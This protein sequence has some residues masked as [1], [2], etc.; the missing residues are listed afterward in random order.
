MENKTR[1]GRSRLADLVVHIATIAVAAAALAYLGYHFF[2]GF[3][4]DIETEYATLVTDSDVVPLDAYIMR[5]ESVIFAASPTSGHSVGYVF[6]DG[7]KVHGGQVVA[8]IYTGDGSSDEAIVDLDRRIDLLESSNLTDGMTS[9]DTYVIDSK[10]QNYYYL[11][12]QSTLLG[13]Y[14][15]LTKRR[16]ELLTLIN[17]RRILTGV[18]TGYSD[19]IE[20]LT[21]ERA[22][23]SAGQDTIA[24]S[25]EAPYVGYF[26]ST[27]DGY[28]ST[29]SASKVESLT[30]AEFD[31]MLSS[32]PTRYSDRAVGKMVSDFDWYIVCETTRDSLRY[33]TKGY[34]YYVNFPY[35]DDISIKMTLSN[36]VS[37]VGSDR[38]LLVLEAERIPEDFSFRRMQPVE[39]V[40]SSY[41]GY[42]VPISAARLVDGKQGVYIMIGN[43]IEFRE[44]DILL[45]MD[46]YYIVAEQ[47]PVNDPDYAS[48]LGLYDQIVVSGKNLYDGK[49]I[50]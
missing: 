32:Q 19:R 20:S 22:L 39:I 40:R 15:N 13:N 18:T 38:V 36:V 17:K 34:S 24:E 44:I 12:H 5:S 30:L 23:L 41:T 25:V 31:K 3:S 1:S 6:S 42:R 4:A 28:E 16:D 11:I 27:T 7:T 26:Y 43:T 47:D 29:F 8:N 9:S 2:E 46:G 35:N 10:I 48:K 14:S 33:F 37:E 49:L 50:S 21:A 45:E